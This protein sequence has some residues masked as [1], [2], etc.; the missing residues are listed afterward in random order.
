MSRT[1]P[2]SCTKLQTGTLDRVV[3]FV[4]DLASVGTGDGDVA[5]VG[6]A[7]DLPCWLEFGAFPDGGLAKVSVLTINLT[8]PDCR[9]EVLELNDTKHLAER[10]GEVLIEGEILPPAYRVI[11]P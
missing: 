6:D 11:R 3:P 4:A 10:A 5:I 2:N 7:S 1:G 9:A 8:D